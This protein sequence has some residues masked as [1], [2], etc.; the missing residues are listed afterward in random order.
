V[1]RETIR[2]GRGEI[3]FEPV[4]RDGS[5]AH[6]SREGNWQAT[7]YEITVDALEGAGA[8]LSLSDAVTDFELRMRMMAQEGENASIFFRQHAGGQ[9]FYQLDLHCRWQAVVISKVDWGVEPQLN[10]I[11]SAVSHEL[12]QGRDY[13]LELA[14]RGESITTCVDG[15]LVNQVR[16]GGYPQGGICLTAWKS[17]TRYVEPRLRIY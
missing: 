9:R 11:I 14:V 17:R 12:L 2:T 16:D 8:W 10:S 4:I 7:R 3:G 1:S 6:L 13:D 5:I 15:K